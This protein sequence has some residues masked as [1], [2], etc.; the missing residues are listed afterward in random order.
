MGIQYFPINIHPI[1]PKKKGAPYILMPH[2]LW[3]QTKILMPITG[4]GKLPLD[5]FSLPWPN[6]SFHFCEGSF[7]QIYISLHVSSQSNTFMRITSYNP[8]FPSNQRKQEVEEYS[9]DSIFQINATLLKERVGTTNHQN[10]WG[11]VILGH[12]A[13]TTNP[14]DISIIFCWNSNSDVITVTSL[15][16]Y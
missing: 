11:I 3:D 1:E 10:P 12:W 5:L 4:L 16:A 14:W 6:M 2:I 8:I 13:H 9:W 7:K 15:K